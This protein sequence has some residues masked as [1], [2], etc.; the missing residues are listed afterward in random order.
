MATS[1]KTTNVLELIEYAN[2]NLSRNDDFATREFKAGVS[3][4]IG[5]ILLDSNNYWGFTFIKGKGNPTD[6]N[7]D[8]KEF[9][10]RVYH[11]HPKLKK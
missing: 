7:F 4:M 1:K 10:N 5:K 9:Y 2:K 3:L 11:V 6:Y 8:G